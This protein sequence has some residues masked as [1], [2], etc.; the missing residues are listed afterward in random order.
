[1]AFQVILWTVCL[2]DAARAQESFEDYFWSSRATTGFD[3][4]EGKYGQAQSTSVAFM[5]VVLQT[6]RGPLTLKISGGALRV[7]GPALILDGA[8]TGGAP[9]A[10]DRKV[11]G[12]SDTSFS[13]MYS[14]RG[15]YDKGIYIDLTAR[16]KFPTAS[17]K[18]GLGTGEVDGVVQADG[19]FA[20]DGFM[21][22]AT[23]GYRANGSPDTLPLRHVI[24]GSLGL[25]YTFSERTSAG[26]AYDYRQSTLKTSADPQEGMAYVSYRFTDTWSLNAYAVA[27]FS[28]NSPNA[29]GGLT[30][31]YR[32][33]PGAV[34]PRR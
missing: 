13:A 3:Y 6:A 31:T 19:A 8:A 1:M 32:F 34:T 12:L 30:F 9:G 21:P 28:K 24:F 23:L 15:L 7:S 16:A 5:P 22:F 26:I 11:S 29:G 27:G 2:P 25:Q 17:F 14:F 10:V 33:H 18:K 20:W 4:S